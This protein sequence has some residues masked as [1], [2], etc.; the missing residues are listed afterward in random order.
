M[1]CDSQQWGS[2]SSYHKDYNFDKTKYEHMWKGVAWT[3]SKIVKESKDYTPHFKYESDNAWAIDEDGIAYFYREENPERGSS[4]WR[5]DEHY[6]MDNNFDANK[7]P[8]MWQ[9]GAWR[10]SLKRK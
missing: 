2:D 8:H 5:S 6:H 9:D 3:N 1:A 10:N 4:A 7:Y